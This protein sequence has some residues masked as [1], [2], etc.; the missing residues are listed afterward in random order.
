MASSDALSNSYPDGL[1][2]Q[3]VHFVSDNMIVGGDSTN[4]RITF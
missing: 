1:R 2:L 3:S 4:W